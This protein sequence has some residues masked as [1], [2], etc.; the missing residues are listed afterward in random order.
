MLILTKK[1]CKK[2]KSKNLIKF[3]KKIVIINPI[4]NSKLAKAKNKNDDVINVNS[5]LTLPTTTVS[6]Y[7][8]TH[9]I[10]ENKIKVNKL[11][12]LIKKKI[13]TK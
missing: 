9:I 11:L 10:S 2:S 3:L 12:Q 13:T 6:E 8:K 4:Q 1:N 5:S 7:N